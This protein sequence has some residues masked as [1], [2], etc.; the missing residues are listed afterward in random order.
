MEI[1]VKIPDPRRAALPIPASR[2][3]SEAIKQIRDARERRIMEMGIWV[4][5]PDSPRAAHPILERSE[6]RAKRSRFQHPAS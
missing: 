5:I 1:W 2:H 6:P 4:K 3:L